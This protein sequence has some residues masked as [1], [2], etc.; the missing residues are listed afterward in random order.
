MNVISS[1]GSIKTFSSTV[2]LQNYTKIIILN[3]FCK[4]NFQKWKNYESN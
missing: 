1:L 3:F 2:S 4:M